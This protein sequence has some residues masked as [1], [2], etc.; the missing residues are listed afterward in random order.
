MEIDSLKDKDGHLDSASIMKIIPY[1]E[2]FLMIDKVISLEKTKI[3]AEK[4]V[5]GKEDFF[6]GHFAGFP[7]MPGALIVEG[8]GQ[9]ATLL[10]R[11]NLP[12]HQDK[13]ILAYKIK[14]AKFSL[15]T[16]PG[17]TIKYEIN[18]VGKDD[19]GALLTAKAVVNNMTVAEATMMLA[20]VERKDF[21]QKHSQ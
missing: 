20:I 3:T 16:F 4:H 2:H 11:Y 15:P 14:D 17:A 6:K 18:L 12:N 10:L 9:A 13:E 1:N 5:S 7:I 8:M 19:K 21:R